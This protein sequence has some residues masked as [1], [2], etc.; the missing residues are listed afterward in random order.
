[1]K[2]FGPFEIEEVIGIVAYKLQ[3]LDHAKM[4]PVFHISQLK[5][6]KGD[7]STP[8]IPLPLI[9]TE[10]GP[11]LQPNQILT[12]RTVIRN[13]IQIPQVLAQWEGLSNHEATWEDVDYL[14]ASYPAYNL[15]DKVVFNGGGI[16]RSP[17]GPADIM[18][19]VQ[20]E[21]GSNIQEE[22]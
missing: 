11:I 13:N 2:Y 1:M 18:G 9:T 16:V 12:A 10:L 21:L 20:P 5:P 22:A 19:R 7:F 3:L 8:Y 4:H 17:R 14:K 6:F 15:E